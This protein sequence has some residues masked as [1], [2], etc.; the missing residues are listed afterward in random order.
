MPN[1][2]PADIVGEVCQVL[3][4]AHRLKGSRR[5]Y[6]TALQIF[7]RLPMATRDRL[8]TEGSLGGPSA[9]ET[10][11]APTIVNSAAALVPGVTTDFLDCRNIAVTIGGATIAPEF[12]VCSLY[13]LETS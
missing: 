9:R 5:C 2:K 3:L 6:L 8:I 13:R 10:H 4:N 7:E 12:E 1:L 11:A